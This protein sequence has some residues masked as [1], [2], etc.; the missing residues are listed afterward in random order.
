MARVVPLPEEGGCHMGNRSIEGPVDDPRRHGRLHRGDG[1][2]DPEICRHQA[3]DGAGVRGLVD[4]P[5][6]ESGAQ[7]DDQQ[8]W[9]AKVTVTPFA[10]QTVQVQ[11]LDRT[12]TRFA[13]S[14]RPASAADVASSGFSQVYLRI[15]AF[16][17]SRCEQ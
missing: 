1:H 9:D 14:L 12:Q 4:D 16:E 3:E 17:P 2:G 13:P 6:R 11:Y 8:R 15:S 7:T 10:N 5:E